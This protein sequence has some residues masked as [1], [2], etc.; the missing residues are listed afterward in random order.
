MYILDTIWH[1]YAFIV[2]VCMHLDMYI[3]K[4]MYIKDIYPDRSDGEIGFRGYVFII[5]RTAG[6]GHINQQK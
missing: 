5:K 3:Y 2:F 1:A 6:G 4:Y